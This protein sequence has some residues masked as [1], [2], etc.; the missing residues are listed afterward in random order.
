MEIKP[1][2]VVSLAI[3]T[4]T[5]LTLGN[6]LPT[7]AAT[8]SHIVISEIKVGPGDDDFVELYNPT[9][10]DIVMSG[11]RLSKKVSTE[12]SLV[13]SLSGTIPSHGYFLITNKDGAS[14]P[15]ANV[16][17]ASSIGANNTILLY[18]DAGTTLVDK[19]GMG[20][21]TDGETASATNP[22]DGKSIERKAMGSSTAVSMA[23]GGTDEFLGNGEDTDN[24][25]SD[26][27]VRDTPQPQ[28]A[29]SAVEN[30]VIATPTPTMTATPT[31]TGTGTPTMSSSPTPTPTATATATPTQTPTQSP[32]PTM[33]ASPTPTMT[34]SPTPT[35]T[36]TPTSSP[37]VTPTMSG[38]PIATTTASPSTTGTPQ[39]TSFP[40]PFG[41]YT[42]RCE[43]TYMTIQSRF[44]IISLPKI[45]CGIVRI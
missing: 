2:H 25:N 45:I 15:S 35:P 27:V 19:V 3:A 20:T 34:A 44:F 8:A 4:V 28:N 39:P 43:V 13:A 9:A 23:I 11:W 16:T 12:S 1:V 42:F 17:Y 24:N 29:Q 41:G 38:T 18:N 33:T 31:A 32:T 6:R 26:F 37:T 14:S 21:A 5:L 30:L 22:A 10:S 36:S 40:F 7:S